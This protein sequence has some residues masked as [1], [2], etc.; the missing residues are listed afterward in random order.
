MFYYAAHN[1]Y[2]IQFGAKGY[3]VFPS[4]ESREDWIE[5]HGMCGSNCVVWPVTCKEVEKNVSRHFVVMSEDKTLDIP[6]FV[7]KK[8]SIN[9][10][11]MYRRHELVYQA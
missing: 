6:M 7:C 2:G 5:N 4:L 1:S 10:Y 11:T 3:F 8:R 9:F